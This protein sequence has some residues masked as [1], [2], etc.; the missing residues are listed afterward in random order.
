MSGQKYS[1]AALLSVIRGHLNTAANHGSTLDAR[2]REALRSETVAGEDTDRLLRLE[3][4][5][6]EVGED[7]YH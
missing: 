1:V 7:R 2:Y 6:S 5:T 4:A 3:A